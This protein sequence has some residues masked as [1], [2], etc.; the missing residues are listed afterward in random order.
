MYIE[1][2][3]QSHTRG[4]ESLRA[5]NFE[6][7][8]AG[9]LK[10]GFSFGRHSPPDHPDVAA[11]V[12]AQGPNLYPDELNGFRDTMDAYFQ[13]ADQLAKKVLG[14]IALTLGL[15]EDYFDKGFCKPP[16]VQRMRMMHYPPQAV[17]APEDERGM[18]PYPTMHA[19]HN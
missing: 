14:I 1:Q 8:G 5:Q 19:G 12:F 16:L 3:K 7:K 4:Y 6:A 11:G 2:N 9:D 17:D 15:E 13:A 10:E 18:I